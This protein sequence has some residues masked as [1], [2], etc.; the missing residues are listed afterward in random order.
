MQTLVAGDAVI[1]AAAGTGAELEVPE[2]EWSRA[3][4]VDDPARW[5]GLALVNVGEQTELL[6][7]RAGFEEFSLAG[8]KFGFEEVALLLLAGELPE[9]LTAS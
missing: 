8:P 9:R 6:E 4:L 7:F 5:E 3:G 2:G 1:V